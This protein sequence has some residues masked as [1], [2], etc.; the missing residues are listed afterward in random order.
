M[1]T[2][3]EDLLHEALGLPDRDRAGLAA[4][5]I[6]SLDDGFDD[7]DDVEAAWAAEIEERSAGVRRGEPTIE[8]SVARQGLL[9]KPDA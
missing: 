7:A 5:L 3:I 2:T 8:W 4:R 6:A 9:A 1:S